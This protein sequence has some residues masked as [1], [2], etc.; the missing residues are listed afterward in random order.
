MSDHHFPER[1]PAPN[2]LDGKGAW[3]H[4]L[5]LQL[6]HHCFT[7]PWLASCRTKRNLLAPLPDAYRL[8]LCSLGLHDPKSSFATKLRGFTF[9]CQQFI[10]LFNSISLNI[11]NTRT[12]PY[13]NH[14]IR[15]KSPKAKPGPAQ[16]EHPEKGRL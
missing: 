4:S 10:I 8:P 2:P 9:S 14:L 15:Q 13:A 11:S 1:I 12:Y 5:C 7:L 6:N 16:K 3:L